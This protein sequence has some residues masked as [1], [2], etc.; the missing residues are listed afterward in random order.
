[1]TFTNSF[2]HQHERSLEAGQNITNNL[3]QEKAIQFCSHAARKGGTGPD[4]CTR[5][6]KRG[7]LTVTTRVMLKLLYSNV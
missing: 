3:L 6:P 5:V 7:H 2:L 4:I 1:M